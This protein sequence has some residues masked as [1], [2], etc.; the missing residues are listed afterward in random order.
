MR[1][2]HC[3]CGLHGSSYRM[4]DFDGEKKNIWIFP[5]SDVTCSPLA[6]PGNG[7][8]SGSGVNYKSVITFACNAGYR[9]V[10][11]SRRTCQTDGTWNGTT[12][13]CSGRS[14]H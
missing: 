3:S 4:Q 1:V 2:L 5:F 6:A 8:I 9:L 13:S 10:G 14:F 7:T 12:A 11:S